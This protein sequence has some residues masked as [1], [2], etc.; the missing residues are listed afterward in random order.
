MRY[1]K[2]RQGIN[3]GIGDRWRRA[4]GACFANAF[5]LGL[6]RVGVTV[7]SVSK[8]GSMGALGTA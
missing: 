7:R 3:D 2:R 1:P 4:D 8:A 6:S 5:R